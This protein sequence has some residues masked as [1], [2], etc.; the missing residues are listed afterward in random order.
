MVGIIMV[1]IIISLILEQKSNGRVAFPTPG[2]EQGMSGKQDL[3]LL[4][5]ASSDEFCHL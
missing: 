1:G 2:S 4:P 5:A 3:G